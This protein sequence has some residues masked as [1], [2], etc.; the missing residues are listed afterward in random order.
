MLDWQKAPGEKTANLLMILMSRSCPR[1]RM[2]ACARI[3][4]RTTR[5]A[6]VG[7]LTPS[8]LI[9]ASPIS[10]FVT[11]TTLATEAGGT[12]TFSGTVSNNSGG[13]L[14]ASDFFFN[15]FGYDS[16]S[17]TP[18]QD[19]GVATDFPIP[20]GTTSPTVALFDIA[21][22]AGSN[23]ASFPVEVQLED[24]SN[25]FTGI[26]KVI[27]SIRSTA[28][29]EPRARPL[30]AAGLLI[31]V[32]LKSRGGKARVPAVAALLVCF[33]YEALAQS[34][35]STQTPV[36]GLDGSTFVVFLP[37]LNSGN[38]M[39]RDVQLTAV[40]LS[41][42]SLHNPSLPYKLPEA[43]RPND[44]DVLDLQFTGSTLG[45]GSR[46]L[47]TVRG[48]YQSGGQVFGFTLNRFVTVTLP[49]SSLLTEIQHWVDIDEV[50]AQGNTLPGM[51]A[52]A[53]NQALLAIIQAN[54]DFVRSGIDAPSSSVWAVFADGTS[55]I[56]GNDRLPAPASGA[57]GTHS[58]A[59][60]SSPH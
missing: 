12:V 26:E 42:A 2:R 53:D 39:V 13:S 49:D 27:V 30:L 20:N 4:M 10:F 19:L 25:D 29:P 43:L 21:L 48:T 16:A 51:D 22:S 7:C 28:A 18:S 47:L 3:L 52:A 55:T 46:H 8:A 50:K 24:I 15:F 5:F 6:L 36:S 60:Q 38:A 34:A 31:L 1:S 40:T 45:A 23:G 33:A 32:F 44:S 11:N 17:V 54:P 14:N 37:V 59:T 57:L 9:W 58:P 41:G 35:L 56:F